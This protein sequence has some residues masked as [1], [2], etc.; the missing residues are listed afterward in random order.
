MVTRVVFNLEM[1]NIKMIVQTAPETCITT[2]DI[3]SLLQHFFEIENCS[4]LNQ[5]FENLL[6]YLNCPLTPI[7]T[8]KM[9]SFCRAVIA[10]TAKVT[11]PILVCLVAHY[12]VGN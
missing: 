10:V 11:V 6:E 9:R 7:C 4:Y 12:L 3:G 5:S 2:R 1:S 8:T